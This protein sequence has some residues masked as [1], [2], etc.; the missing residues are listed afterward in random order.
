[1]TELKEELKASIAEI[2][3]KLPTI[4]I[5]GKEYTMVKDRIVYF[6]QTYPNGSITTEILNDFH[7]EERFI[8]NAVVIP[9]V[10]K[11][12]RLFTGKSQALIDP[13]S[14]INSVSALENAETSAI[15]RALGMMGIGV[16]E[17]VASADELH[18]AKSQTEVVEAAK[19]RAAEQRTQLAQQQGPFVLD[20]DVLTCII[21][22]V[23][24]KTGQGNKPFLAVTFNGRLPNGSNFASCFDKDLWD[25]L[26][27]LLDKESK[28]KIKMKDKFTNITDI[29]LTE[30]V[31][32]E[33]TDDEIGF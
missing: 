4:L 5:K 15:G 26:G 16:I 13:G 12:T 17:S 3:D 32:Y 27:K 23:Q 20:G 24:Q 14:M 18:K 22:G 29:I 1:M 30:P 33:P 28:L 7:T 6:N 25:D 10:D 2:D 8:I 11:P 19:L 21:K 31:V 9:D